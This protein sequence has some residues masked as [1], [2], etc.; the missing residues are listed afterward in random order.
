MIYAYSLGDLSDLNCVN[1]QSPEYLNDFCWRNFARLLGK[2]RFAQVCEYQIDTY[3]KH[4]PFY[5]HPLHLPELDKLYCAPLFNLLKFT[6]F[7]QIHTFCS[8]GTKPIPAIG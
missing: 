2:G 1:G 4:E 6:K 5:L 7:A 3:Q 8:W